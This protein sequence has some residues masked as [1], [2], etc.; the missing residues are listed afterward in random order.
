[1]V[2]V[3]GDLCVDWHRGV[4]RAPG[5]GDGIVDRSSTGR[6]AGFWLGGAGFSGYPHIPRPYNEYGFLLRLFN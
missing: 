3:V 1:L 6:Q 4:K 5:V 2:V